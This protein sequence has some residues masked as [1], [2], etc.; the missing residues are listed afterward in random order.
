MWTDVSMKIY[1]MV[2]TAAE[3]LLSSEE[4]LNG[5][6]KESGDGDCG[7]TMARGAQGIVLC[8][9]VLHSLPCMRNTLPQTGINSQIVVMIGCRCESIQSKKLFYFYKK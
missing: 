3:R 4:K 2:K 6:D 7:S 1:D 9:Y 5:L 8:S